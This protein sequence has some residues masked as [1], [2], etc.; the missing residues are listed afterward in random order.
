M[1]MCWCMPNKIPML[2]LPNY[3]H[4]LEHA[5][6]RTIR[7]SCSSSMHIMHSCQHVHTLDTTKE[8]GKQNDQQQQQHAHDA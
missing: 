2:Q 5:T 4:A 8:N 6:Q 7:T 3:A 1:A